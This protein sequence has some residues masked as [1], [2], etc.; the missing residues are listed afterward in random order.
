MVAVAAMVAGVM[1]VGVAYATP[2]ALYAISDRYCVATAHL[3][4]Y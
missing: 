4:S 1:V 2:D 3:P